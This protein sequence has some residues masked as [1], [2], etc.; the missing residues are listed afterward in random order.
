MQHHEDSP[1]ASPAVSPATQPSPA[2]RTRNASG[3]GPAGAGTSPGELSTVE[4]VR[5]ITSEVGHLVQK[6]LE[7][8]KA[9]LRANLKSEAI[10]VGGL[11]LAALAG[12]CTINLLLVTVAL[13]LTTVLPGWAAGLLVSGATLLITAVVA[14]LAWSSRVRSPMSR[15]RR[16]LQE[17]VRWTRERLT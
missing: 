8:A 11:S 3:A 9:E 17:D 5:Q 16:T 15:T 6:Q 4:L 14:T 2:P 13:A 10:M 12:L 1:A 7:L